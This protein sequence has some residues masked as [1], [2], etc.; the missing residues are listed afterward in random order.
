MW[1]TKVLTPSLILETH[2][3]ANYYRF[4][5]EGQ[6]EGQRLEKVYNSLSECQDGALKALTGFP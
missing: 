1:V 4:H 3:K 2:I 5:N 6:R